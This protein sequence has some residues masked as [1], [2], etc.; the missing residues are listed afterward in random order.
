MA[1]I[2]YIET[3]KR[4]KKSEEIKSESEN[5]TEKEEMNPSDES[6]STDSEEAAS[7]ISELLTIT[8]ILKNIQNINLEKDEPQSTGVT[9]SETICQCISACNTRRCICKASNAKCK[10]NCHPTSEKC[11]NFN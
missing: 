11:A 5:D 8:N 3:N 4:K 9:T 10:T 2:L 7:C 1:S 6:D